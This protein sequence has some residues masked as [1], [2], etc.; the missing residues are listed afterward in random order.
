MIEEIKKNKVF[1]IIYAIIII[2]LICMTQ[3]N[4]KYLVINNDLNPRAGL[5]E[6][7]L[8][9]VQI[10]DGAPT[11]Q[12]SYFVFN[13]TLS[14]VL[15]LIALIIS[16]NKNNSL[17]FKWLIALAIIILYSLVRFGVRRDVGDGTENIEE[18]YRGFIG[19][20]VA[21]VLYMITVIRYAASR[22]KEKVKEPVKKEI[23]EEKKKK[24]THS[25]LLNFYSTVT[26]LAKFLGLSTSNP[27]SF[28]I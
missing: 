28:E 23:K 27:F 2:A 3:F 10:V 6:S 4:N 19:A 26:D 25:S 7:Q 13:I 12:Y 18:I 11:L 8:S 5:S 17:K 20:S 1:L 16:N 14:S 15:T 9:S 24:W 21:I 22:S